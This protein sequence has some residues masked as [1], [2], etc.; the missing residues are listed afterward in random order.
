[1][2]SYQDKEKIKTFLREIVGA[3]IVEHREEGDVTG[4]VDDAGMNPDGSLGV[5]WDDGYH[6]T[7]VFTP[8]SWNFSLNDG[9]LTLRRTAP[10]TRTSD[11]PW[12]TANRY[13]LTKK[14]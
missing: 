11:C 2:S 4:D 13:T 8:K 10:D 12:R 1:M 7:T 3:T 9:I 14:K 6:R 5:Y